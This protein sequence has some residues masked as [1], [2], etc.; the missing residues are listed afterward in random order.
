[1]FLVLPF[2]M[3]YHPQLLMSC[4]SL[5]SVQ[6]CSCH[7]P[8]FFILLIINP[9]YESIHSNSYLIRLPDDFQSRFLPNLSMLCFIQHLTTH[10]VLFS[11]LH[12]IFHY[13]ITS[14]HSQN[15]FNN[16]NILEYNFALVANSVA[17]RLECI[18]MYIF[19]LF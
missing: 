4:I 14:I 16:H 13:I 9:V 19:F 10:C 2:Q 3:E 8:L 5:L 12:F 15:L 17:T 6:E 1:M 7:F 11:F 18:I